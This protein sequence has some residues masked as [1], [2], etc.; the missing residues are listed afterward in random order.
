MRTIT[1]IITHCSATPEGKNFTVDDIDAWH[2]ERGWSEI[3][4]H[5]VI[6]LDG[7]IH[8]GRPIE[9]AGAHV[10][11]RNRY[12]IGVCYIGGV[13]ANDKKLAR[14]TRTPAQKE[15]L[16]KLFKQLLGKYPTINKIS[17]H[18]D[19]A[20]KACPCFP[21][22]QE[23]AYLVAD[24]KSK[25]KVDYSQ[26]LHMGDGPNNGR[27]W[28]VKAL[29]Q[30]L[31]ELGYRPGAADGWFGR[32]TRNAVVAFQMDEEITADGI[33]GTETK[34]ALATAVSIDNGARSVASAQDLKKDSRI[35][36]KGSQM[37][38]LAGASAGV[39]LLGK[40]A[41]EAGIIDSAQSLLGQG[42]QIRYMLG[43]SA[44]FVNWAVSHW[45]IIIPIVAGI[46][47]WNCRDI[48]SARV[49]DH[50]TGKTM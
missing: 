1:E 4:Y 18:H 13:S 47:W 6:Y 2:K 42:N 27:S 16:I 28:E 5:F 7:T 44:D 50:Q 35:V 8:E 31:V 9:K 33:V 17:G 49:E 34:K 23:Y 45:W 22:T 32:G 11:G 15:S 46:V 24:R 21:A 30:R 40:G 41:D 43:D 29:Q 26:L 20:A 14:D 39:T 12:T 3:G 38:T 36:K 25:S 19:Y 10:S 37:Q 48:V